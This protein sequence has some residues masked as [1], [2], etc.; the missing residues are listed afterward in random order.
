VAQEIWRTLPAQ[1]LMDGHYAGN[2]AFVATCTDDLTLSELRKNLT[3]G[4]EAQGDSGIFPAVFTTLARDY[5]KLADCLT[6]VNGAAR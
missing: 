4:D 6:Q 5:Q 2:L 3:V 1:L